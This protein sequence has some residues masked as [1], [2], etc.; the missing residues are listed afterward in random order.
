MA[1]NQVVRLMVRGVYDLQ[2]VRIQMGNRIVANFRSKLGI[3]DVPETATEKDKAS[4]A[5]KVL[6]AITESYNRV[7]DAIVDS[8]HSKTKLPSIK[9][10]VGDGVI[11]TYSE[12]ILVN[13]YI[14]ILKD[15]EKQFRMLGKL[16]KDIPIYTNFLKGVKGVGPAMAGV[17]ISEVDI[18]CAEY[19]SSLWAYA[20]LDSVTVAVYTNKHGKEIRL[21]P[22]ALDVFYE[23][24][25]PSA[26]YLAEGKYP[27]TFISVGRSMKAECL[28]KR[29]YI[30]RDGEEQE[31]NSITF[32]PFL[33]AKLMGVLSTSFLRTGSPYAENYYRYKA[34]IENSPKHMEKTAVHRHNMALRYM[35]KRFLV[36]FYTA[37]RGMENL[38]VATEYSEGKLG[39]VH[40]KA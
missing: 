40:G 5:K 2:A 34:R 35:V 4:E 31:K 19:P 10:F 11:S 3:V 27:I 23:E 15:E 29:K 24:N 9:K 21:P 1:K 28:V 18:H 37:Y 38:P 33:K 25:G 30:D 8:E 16:L 32:N 13:L 20:G 12:L 36:D 26:E 14:S 7:T 22:W 17:L 6:D 39:M